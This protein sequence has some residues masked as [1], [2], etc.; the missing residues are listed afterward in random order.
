MQ[1]NIGWASLFRIHRLGTTVYCI[2]I[3]VLELLWSTALAFLKTVWM[4]LV[5][6]TRKDLQ[7]YL[8]WSYVP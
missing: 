1:F 8:D 4:H 6:S 5:I 2:S 3:A 7:D